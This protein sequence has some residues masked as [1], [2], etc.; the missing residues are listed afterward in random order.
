MGVPRCMQPRGP[1]QNGTHH[2]QQSQAPRELMVGGPCAHLDPPHLLLQAETEDL[3]EAAGVG[4]ED[5]LGVAKAAEPGQHVVQLMGKGIQITPA[6]Q[7]AP[8]SGLPAAGT[9]CRGL[10]WCPHS[11]Q[12]LG[13]SLR[14]SQGPQDPLLA[15]RRRVV[16]GNGQLPPPDIL[17]PSSAAAPGRSGTAPSVWRLL[18]SL[19]RCARCGREG[20]IAYPH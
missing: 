10:G 7:R 3:A 2:G 18:S 5:C 16:P 12:C 6:E 17:R 11:S 13:L 20:P 15:Q 19:S 1:A 4:I 9:P 14:R 8:W